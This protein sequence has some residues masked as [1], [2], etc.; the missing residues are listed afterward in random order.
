MSVIEEMIQYATSRYGE[1]RVAQI[2]TYGTIKAKQAVKDATRV[3]G[4]PYVVG[5]KIN[6]SLPPSVMGKDISSLESSILKMN[7]I[8][9]LERFERSTTAMEMPRRSSIQRADSKV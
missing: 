1:E 2:I 6:K 3:L 8:S 5:E 7:D 9:K 4:L